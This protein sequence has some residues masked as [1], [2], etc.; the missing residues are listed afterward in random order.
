[1][2]SF[3]FKFFPDQNPADPAQSSLPSAANP[4]PG[5]LSTLAPVSAQAQSQ[6]AA[7]VQAVKITVLN[8]AY[9][10]GNTQVKS[11]QPIRLT[12]V[13]DKTF[14]CTRAFNIRSL[15]IQKVMPTSGQTIINL[16]AQKPGVIRYVCGMGMY[17]GTITVI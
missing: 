15:G 1:M 2:H 13:T 14:G 12:L 6:A 7:E 11:G 4:A 3:N 10:L 8:D 16:P 17:T 9:Q 5:G